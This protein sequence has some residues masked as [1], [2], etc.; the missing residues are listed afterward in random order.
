[1]AHDGVHCG[2]AQASIRDFSH[3]AQDLALCRLHHGIACS[4]GMSGS[5]Q[6]EGT[7]SWHF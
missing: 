5:K 7:L 3:S 1:M 6:Q 4:A 2:R